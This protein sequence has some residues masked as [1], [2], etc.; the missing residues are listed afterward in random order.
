YEDVIPRY[1]DTDSIGF[2]TISAGSGTASGMSA[3]VWHTAI[4]VRDR[5]I[6]RAAQIWEV[7]PSA[8]AYDS[9]TG[10]LSTTATETEP[11]RSMTFRELAARQ[12]STGG[13][14]SGHVDQGNASGA[15]TFG[16]HIVD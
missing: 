14:I 12:A 6:E 15:A 2:T 4:Q 9:S 10:V 7:E 8:V 16:I 5:L 3:S 13:Y 11:E 1:A